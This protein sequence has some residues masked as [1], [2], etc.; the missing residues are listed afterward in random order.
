MPLTTPRPPQRRAVRLLATAA[1]CLTTALTSLAGA[2]PAV[3][4]PDAGSRAGATAVARPP[5]PSDLP[6]G[7]EAPAS[8]VYSY[9]CDMRTQP[10]SKAL[11]DLLVSTYPGTSYGL[12]RVCSTQG[13]HSDGRA[14]DWMAGV[15]DATT[16]AEAKTFLRWL[17][18]PDAEGHRFANARRLGVMYLIYDGR[19]WGSYRWKEGWREYQ[20]CSTRTSRSYDTYCHRDHVHISLSYAG[21]RKKTSYWSKSVAPEEFGPCRAAQMNW[22]G[23]YGPVHLSPCPESDGLVIKGYSTSDQRTL[24]AFTGQRLTQGMT[25]PGVAA[26]QRVLG[27]TDTGYFGPVTADAVADFKAGQGL[28]RDSIVGPKAWLAL[29]REFA[30]MALAEPR[31][32]P[33]AP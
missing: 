23:R 29:V 3:A 25:S 15:R 5:V 19:I 8:Y 16:H 31:R 14:I 21:A 26:V 22:A 20:D 13:E 30:P 17:L 12:N 2:V 33:A 27:V 1:A 18:T 11:G 4:G 7:I 6:A 28:H 24:V 9:S 32:I 10:G